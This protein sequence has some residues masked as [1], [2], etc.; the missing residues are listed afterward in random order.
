MQMVK[1]ITPHSGHVLKSNI[2]DLKLM[3]DTIW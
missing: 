1:H 3:A 2:V